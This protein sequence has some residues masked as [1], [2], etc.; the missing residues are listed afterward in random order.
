MN[1]TAQFSEFGT[2]PPMSRSL[3]SEFSLNGFGLDQET[4]PPRRKSPQPQ[5]NPAFPPLELIGARTERPSWTN[6]PMGRAI[7]PAM[8]RNANRSRSPAG[9]DRQPGNYRSRTPPNA[10]QPVSGALAPKYHLFPQNA[11]SNPTRDVSTRDVPTAQ[12]PSLPSKSLSLPRRGLAPIR[13]RLEDIEETRPG[14]ISQITQDLVTER[15][16][17]AGPVSQ[18]TQELNPE[19]LIADALA[20]FIPQPLTLPSPNA[21]QQTKPKKRITSMVDYLSLDEL[22]SL[23]QS[24]DMYL[25]I[26]N[27]PVKPQSPMFRVSPDPRS[28]VLPIHP[29]FRNDP[30]MANAHHNSF[31]CT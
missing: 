6:R 14:P 21:Q 26:V 25:G 1:N 31:A 2:R 12:R 22:E 4:Q 20:E 17:S 15:R 5:R 30:I 23:W 18:V 11:S 29:A 9:S 7:A 13:E 10:P 24:Q 27:A 28:P 3:E 19:Q 16:P 8:D